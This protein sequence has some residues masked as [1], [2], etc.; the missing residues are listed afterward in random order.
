[1][2]IGVGCVMGR[3]SCGGKGLCSASCR[4]SG[5]SV[6]EDGGVGCGSGCDSEPLEV[7]LVDGT[8]GILGLDEELGIGVTGGA[9]G[10]GG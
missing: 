4:R 3:Y 7:V 10:T 6:P 1:M 2:R 8:C 5:I 9:G